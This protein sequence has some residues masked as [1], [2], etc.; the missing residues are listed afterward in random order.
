MLGLVVAAVIGN[1]HHLTFLPIPPLF[2][3]SPVIILRPPLTGRISRE[4]RPISKIEF[5]YNGLE[6]TY[7]YSRFVLQ[8]T[9]VMLNLVIAVIIDNFIE[10]AQSEGLLKV[11]G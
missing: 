4:R 6:P 1:L 3:P 2:S 10:N 9:F 7:T 8:G 11:W 5:E